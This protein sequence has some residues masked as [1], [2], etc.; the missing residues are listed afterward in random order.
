MDHF[1]LRDQALAFQRQR[2][3]SNSSRPVRAV[4]PLML[5]RSSEHS[6]DEFHLFISDLATRDLFIEG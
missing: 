6:H 3:K 1:R 5:V 4:T 2:N